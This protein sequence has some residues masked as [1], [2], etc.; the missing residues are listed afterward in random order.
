VRKWKDAYLEHGVAGLC[1][2]HGT[3][4]GDFKISVVEYM[5]NTGYI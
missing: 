2:T 1:Y 5:K 4:T 3:Y